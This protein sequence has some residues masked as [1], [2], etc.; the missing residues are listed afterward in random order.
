MKQLVKLEFRAY[1]MI[2]GIGSLPQL[3]LN[4]MISQPFGE[5]T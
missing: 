2:A 5:S 1:S 4:I 3:S